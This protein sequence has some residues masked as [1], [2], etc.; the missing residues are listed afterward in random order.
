M[1][2]FLENIWLELTPTIF[3]DFRKYKINK[4]KLKPFIE[5]KIKQILEEEDILM[6][7][8]PYDEINKDHVGPEGEK[9]IGLFRYLKG[10]LNDETYVR[11]MYLLSE[12]DK[13][14]LDYKYIYPRI[15]ISEKGDL[16]TKL[17]EL[18]HYFLYKK[19]VKQSEK[20]ADYY[21]FTFFDKHLPPFFKWIFSIELEVYS[22]TELKFSRRQII[23]FIKEYRK[24]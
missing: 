17:H 4:N 22:E 11:Y 3:L 8:V 1:N 12:I 9:A 10:N 23:N 21:I 18:G 5:S 13:T 14:K 7:D 16:F 20:A 2:K 15:E 24:F 19:N 6:V